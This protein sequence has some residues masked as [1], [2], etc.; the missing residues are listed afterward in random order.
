MQLLSFEEVAELA[1][2]FAKTF[3]DWMETEE[4]LADQFRAAATDGEKEQWRFIHKQRGRAEF[5]SATLSAF[6]D[7]KGLPYV[8]H[9]KLSYAEIFAT[10]GVR[11]FGEEKMKEFV[12]A[13]ACNSDVAGSLGM[14][15]APTLQKLCR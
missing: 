14:A 7:K 15:G 11:A 1:N 13:E 10:V 4:G 2:D 5:G 9:L 6:G 12:P 3:D 8:D